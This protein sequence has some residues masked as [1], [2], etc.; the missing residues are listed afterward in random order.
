MTRFRIAL[1]AAAAA[2]AVTSPAIARTSDLV[3]KVQSEAGWQGVE[4]NTIR[5]T[6]QTLAVAG[7][8]RQGRDV[9]LTMSC[10]KLGYVC[11]GANDGRGFTAVALNDAARASSDRSAAVSVTSAAN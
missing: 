11:E 1:I 2:A 3:A 6:G 9:L 4:V 8:D 5:R 7:Y 10:E